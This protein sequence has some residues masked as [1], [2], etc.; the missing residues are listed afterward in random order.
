MIQKPFLCAVIVTVALSS[1]CGRSEETAAARRPKETAPSADKVL[2]KTQEAVQVT[3]EYAYGQKDE[4][5]AKTTE[6]LAEVQK[7][8]DRLAAQ[9]ESTRDDARAEAKAK[10]QIVRDKADSLRR[11]VNELKR[12]TASSWN[13]VRAGY[14]NTQGELKSAFNDARRWLADKIAP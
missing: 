6:E 14:N 12:A 2:A 3:K 4:F 7:E 1:S 9:V 10:L 8:I 11:Q 13:E 5:I